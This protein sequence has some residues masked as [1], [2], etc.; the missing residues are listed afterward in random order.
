VRL[1]HWAPRLEAV[2]REGLL[3]S[4]SSTPC[5]HVWLARSPAGAACNGQAVEADV[6]C[7]G[8]E[9]DRQV[10]YHGGIGPER[11]RRLQLGEDPV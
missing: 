3:A 11:L 8:R 5:C 1:Y 7:L 2:L 4:R 10:C 6:D 9:L